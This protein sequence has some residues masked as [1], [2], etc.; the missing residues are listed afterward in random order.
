M[1]KRGYREDLISAALKKFETAADATGISLYQANLRTYQ[2]LR[3]GVKVQTAI[4]KDYETV[5]LID[6]EHPENND[7]ALA[8]EV[9]L[10]G[11]YPFQRGIPPQRPLC[12]VRLVERLNPPARPLLRRWP[13]TAPSNSLR[14]ISRRPGP[15]GN[16]APSL[17]AGELPAG[18]LGRGSRAS[19]PASA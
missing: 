10:K 5:H 9:T 14:R 3:Y 7:F 4:G 18:S 19:R 16:T 13:T 17:R 6:W 8:E 15:G 11:G 1:R 12:A 2:L